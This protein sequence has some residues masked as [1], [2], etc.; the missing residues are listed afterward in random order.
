[1]AAAATNAAAPRVAPPLAPSATRRRATTTTTRRS[2]G[3]G[4]EGVPLAD[5]GASSSRLRRIASRPVPVA[6][7]PVPSPS[8]RIPSRPRP[9]SARRPIVHRVASRL[10]SPRRDDATSTT[11]PPRP[12][13]AVIHFWHLWASSPACRAAVQRW[14]KGSPF[15]DAPLLESRVRALT[16]VFD[17]RSGVDVPALL[18]RE[19]ELLLRDFRDVTRAVVAVKAAAPEMDGAALTRAPGLLLCD[20]ED[21]AR[22]RR[23]L[24]GEVGKREAARLIRKSPEEL[25]KRTRRAAEEDEMRAA[26]TMQYGEAMEPP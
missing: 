14:G 10:T 8:R 17:A 15:R 2:S 1:M 7:H 5:R 23:A 22:A 9:S 13:A 25:M 16:R 21:L 6:S 24:E 18:T 19:P 11:H 26:V 3:D 20:A 4:V 12:T